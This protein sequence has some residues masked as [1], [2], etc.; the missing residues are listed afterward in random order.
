[1]STE[2]DLDVSR[3]TF[4]K[5]KAFAE[6]VRKWNPK[7]NLVS[8]DSLND[9]W[10]RHILD[11]VQ[12]FELVP[13]PGKWVDLGSGGGFPGI[14]ISILN[15]EERN[16]DVVMVESDQRKSAFLRTAIR[17]LDLA[18]KVKTERI[19]E[20][21]C[22]E[23]DV[24]SARALADLTKLLGFAELHLK[25]GGIALFPKGQSWQREDLEARQD[26]NYDLE[27]VT[28]KTNSD[29]AILKIK[30]IARV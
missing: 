11:S 17:E 22:L 9:L 21:E 4:E 8:K 30:D 12:I 28:S 19:E 1:M 24:L 2:N 16:F 15:Q 20:L 5:L 3:E 29:A 14:V 6:L 23:A 10:S 25:R 7:I 18:A 13:G 26:W 27:T